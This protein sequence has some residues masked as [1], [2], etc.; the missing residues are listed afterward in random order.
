MLERDFHSLKRFQKVKL[1]LDKFSECLLHLFLN[2]VC[3]LAR[4]LCCQCSKVLIFFGQDHR[5]EVHKTHEAFIVAI[6]GIFE[7]FC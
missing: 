3:R 4:F 5:I 2:A 7:P 6:I 1:V